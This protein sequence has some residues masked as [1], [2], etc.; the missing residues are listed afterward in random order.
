MKATDHKDDF[1]R[2]V[3]QWADKLDVEVVWLGVRPMRNK[4]A[5]CSTAGNLNFN[6]ELLA[7]D[8]EIGDYSSSTRC[9]IFSFR[10]TVS[11]RKACFL[12][13]SIISGPF[14]PSG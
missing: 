4:W 7:L 3:R 6:A 12:K 13:S 8:R 5:S 2:R 9:C 1:K 14:F 11:K 10:I